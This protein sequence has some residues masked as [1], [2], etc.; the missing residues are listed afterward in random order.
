MRHVAPQQTA[1][2]GPR[3]LPALG[4]LPLPGNPR[5]AKLASS[6]CRGAYANRGSRVRETVRLTRVNSQSH[7][8]LLSC[9]SKVAGDFRPCGNITNSYFHREGTSTHAGV[10]S[11]SSDLEQALC[12]ERKSVNSRDRR[13]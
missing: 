1:K 12:R 9:G 4:K 6:G 5:L 2:A 10:L 7:S 11:L 3:L 13:D 8:V